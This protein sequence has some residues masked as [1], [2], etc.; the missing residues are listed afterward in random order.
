MKH[1]SDVDGESVSIITK[2]NITICNIFGHFP[3]ARAFV[4]QGQFA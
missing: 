1:K 2:L 4:Q 3:D